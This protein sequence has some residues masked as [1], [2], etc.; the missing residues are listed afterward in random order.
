MTGTLAGT[1]EGIAEGLVGM[2][3]APPAAAEQ[4]GED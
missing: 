3:L 4:V 1:V 2:R